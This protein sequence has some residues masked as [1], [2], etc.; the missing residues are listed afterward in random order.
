MNVKSLSRVQLFV[1]P[2]TGAYPAPPSKEFSRQEYWSCHF[3]LQG[4]FLTQGSNPT[5]LHCRQTLYHL[6]HLGSPHKHTYIQIYLLLK[7]LHRKQSKGQIKISD[8]LNGVSLVAQLVKNLS[9]MQ[10]T[11]VQFMDWKDPLEKE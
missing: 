9:A 4:I 3:L 6:S 7:I 10:E 11:L 2:W 8:Q 1:T 5:L